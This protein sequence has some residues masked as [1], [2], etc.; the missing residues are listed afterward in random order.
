MTNKYKRPK[1]IAEKIPTALK[2]SH[3]RALPSGGV[4]DADF[5]GTDFGCS[6]IFILKAL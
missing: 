3:E 5:E 6:A 4:T 2:I 1:T